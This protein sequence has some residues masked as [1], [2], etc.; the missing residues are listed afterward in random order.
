MKYLLIILVIIL[1]SGEIKAQKTLTYKDK[2]FTYNVVLK[3]DSTNNKWDSDGFVQSIAVYKI[4]DKKLVQTI[5][6]PKNSTNITLPADQI[7]ILDDMNFDGYN[8]FSIIELLPAGPNIPYFCWTFNPKSQQFQRDTC[9]EEI[10]SPNFDHK[11]KLI[12]SF[13]RSNYCD[14]GFSVY[15]YINGKLTLISE[16]ET[17]CDFNHP[18]IYSVTSKR[19]VNGRMKL[20]KKT[21]IKDK[22]NGK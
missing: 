8:D 3:M 22:I 21:I 5:T 15:K 12:T 7:F 11:H 9:L 18:D 6:P 16:D 1:F 19:L 10:T 4:A 17:A 13:W 2:I 14:H 20:I